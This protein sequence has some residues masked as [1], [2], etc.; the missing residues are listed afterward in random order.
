MSDELFTLFWN[1]PFSQWHES[2]FELDGVEYGCAE[3]YMM[4][5]KARLF[6]DDETLDMIMESDDP[7]Q[8]K[9]LGRAVHGFDLAK[10]QEEDDDNYMPFCWNAVWR[11]NMAKFSQ[12]PGLLE[13]LLA[14]KG[15]TLVEASPRDKIWGIG[16]GE[17]DPGCRD[18]L[19]WQ[20]TNWLGE[21]LTN[22]RGHLE[23]DPTPYLSSDDPRKP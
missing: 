21:V 11:G 6:E 9:K 8:Q 12:N 22:V 14:T 23:V 18:R 3:Q 2:D 1:G 13:E 16:L 15:T 10:W 20:G 19:S 5:E 7:L 4:A 17:D